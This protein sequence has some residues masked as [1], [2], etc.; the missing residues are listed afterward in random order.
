MILRDTELTIPTTTEP[1]RARVEGH[2][3]ELSYMIGETE[4]AVVKYKAHLIDQISNIC[5]MIM[6]GFRTEQERTGVYLIILC[7]I[8]R[9]E[10][11]YFRTKLNTPV[12]N[13]GAIELPR[14]E[15]ILEGLDDMSIQNLTVPPPDLLQ[16]APAEPSSA[17]VP[18]TP[19]APGGGTPRAPG[20][21]VPPGGG[22]PTTPGTG[23][24]GDP[25]VRPNQNPGLKSAWVATGNQGVF[26]QGSPYRDDTASGDRG[27]RTV[28]SDTP[29]VRCCL[30]MALTGRCYTSCRGKHDALSP[31]EEQRVAAAGGLTL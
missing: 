10:G 19:R 28:P 9:E 14:Y 26:S 15:R 29:N 16:P 30:P 7:Y 21:G 13:H 11:R 20:G 5:A 12:A 23:G 1:F 31:A 27:R 3:A 22:T 4:P 17:L 8:W 18:R 2:W 25:D 24:S 6:V